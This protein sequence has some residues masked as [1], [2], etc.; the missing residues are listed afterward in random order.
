MIFGARA[1]KGV[2]EANRLVYFTAT[3]KSPLERHLYAV[4]L[5]SPNERRMNR[6]SAEDGVHAIVMSPDSRFYVD[7]FTSVLQPPQV[8]LHGP[9]GALITYLL[10]NRL[11]DQHP[12][13]PYIAE[14]S[15]PD[16]G[17]LTAADGQTLHYRLFKPL[18]FDPA[19]RYPAV[20]KCTAAPVCS[21]SSI[22][23]RAAHSPRY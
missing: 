9:D 23:G 5:D 4:S 1:M 20:V 19:K 17:T 3:Q 2:D 11:N 7:T 15:I 16:F 6:I 18:H 12:D 21:G 8:G 10:E 13:A 22:P 14:N